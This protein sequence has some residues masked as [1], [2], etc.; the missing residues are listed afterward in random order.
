VRIEAEQSSLAVLAARA[1]LAAAAL[2]R[3][4]ASKQLE[5]AEA[6]YAVGMGSIIELGDAQVTE[7]QAE[8]QEVNA[9]YALAAARASLMGALGR[10]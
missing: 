4:N 1:T 8:A 9:H 7:T 2:A 6:R 10:Q 3:Q 5:L